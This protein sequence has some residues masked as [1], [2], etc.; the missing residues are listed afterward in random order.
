M[1]QLKTGSV[2]QSVAGHDEGFFAVVKV[3]NDFVYIANG[4][5]RLLEN[6]KKKNPKHLR[7]SAEV[8]EPMR[9]ETN[10]KLK[11][12]LWPYN[13]GGLTPSDD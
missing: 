8:F 13:Y 12:A 11:K 9:M 2:V 10:K 7:V 4:K 5:T 1:P 3:E 6:P